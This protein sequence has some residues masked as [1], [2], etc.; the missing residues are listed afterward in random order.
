MLSTHI[1]IITK[2]SQDNRNESAYHFV[3]KDIFPAIYMVD[4]TFIMRTMFGIETGAHNFVRINL[5]TNLIFKVY[6]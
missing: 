1:E 4:I 3:L 5:K 2:L 6:L